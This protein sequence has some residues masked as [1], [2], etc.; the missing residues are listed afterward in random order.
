MTL[1]YKNDCCTFKAQYLTGYAT[2]ALGSR[3]KDDTVLFTLE[4]RTLGA[5]SYSSDV[6]NLYSSVDGINIFEMSAPRRAERLERR[7]SLSLCSPSP[8]GS[9]PELDPS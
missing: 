3:V 4:L 8:W 7:W 9:P 2:S 6:T 5:I 1:Q